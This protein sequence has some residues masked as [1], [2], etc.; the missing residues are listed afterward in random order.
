MHGA[1]G[2]RPSRADDL[3]QRLPAALTAEGA[4]RRAKQ[5]STRPDRHLPLRRF[6]SHIAPSMRPPLT[7]QGAGR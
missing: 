2:P 3:R 5:E 7:M 1:C 4:A 6:F